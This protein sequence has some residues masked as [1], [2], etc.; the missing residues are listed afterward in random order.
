[1]LAQEAANYIDEY[2]EAEMPSHLQAW[3]YASE[4]LASALAPSNKPDGQ[5]ISFKRE[6]KLAAGWLNEGAAACE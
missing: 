2:L 5:A 1:M 3:H 4:L 6:L